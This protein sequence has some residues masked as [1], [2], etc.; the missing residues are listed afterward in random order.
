MFGLNKLTSPN[1]LV[2]VA[3]IVIAVLWARNRVPFLA[4]LTS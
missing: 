4:T 1:F 3:V 2:P